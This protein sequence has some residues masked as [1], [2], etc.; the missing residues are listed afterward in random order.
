VAT[1]REGEGEKDCGSSPGG[2]APEGPPASDRGSSLVRTSCPSLYARRQA[3]RA[4][5]AASS[6]SSCEGRE[7]REAETS[8]SAH[9]SSV[10]R[11]K[12]ARYTARHVHAPTSYKVDRRALGSAPNVLART[13]PSL[14]AAAAARSCS[15]QFAAPISTG[16]P[17]LEDGTVKVAVGR[18]ALVRRLEDDARD[19]GVAERVRCRGAE[20][21]EPARGAQAPDAGLGL[22]GRCRCRGCGRGERCRGRGRGGSGGAHRGKKG[23]QVVA[24]A[25]R[26]GRGSAR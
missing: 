1:K 4:P 8:A 10:D 13:S 25:C 15:R 12:A 17:F 23:P 26:K 24:A 2:R 20:R 9:E 16:R 18:R 14:T 11:A 21:L 6:R 5:G 3:D 7:A 19:D 22:L